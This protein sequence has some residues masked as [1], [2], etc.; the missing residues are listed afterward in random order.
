M[1]STTPSS[2]NNNNTSKGLF[3]SIGSPDTVISNDD[4]R[5]HVESFLTSL[6]ERDDVLILP[7]GKSA[8]VHI[9]LSCESCVQY[10]VSV[11]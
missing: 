3:C 11:I 2:S 8:F 5:Q 9:V 4:L 10:E 1:A 6:G 7:P